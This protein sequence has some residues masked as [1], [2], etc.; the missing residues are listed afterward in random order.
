MSRNSRELINET[1]RARKAFTFPLSETLFE[2]K[3]LRIKL[4][5]TS[6]DAFPGIFQ[7]SP[8]MTDVRR[9]LAESLDSLG[10]LKYHVSESTSSFAEQTD[11]GLLERLVYLNRRSSYPW[12]NGRV[13]DGRFAGNPIVDDSQLVVPASESVAVLSSFLPAE[14]SPATKQTRNIAGPV[15]AA[16]LLTGPPLLSTEMAPYVTRPSKRA[17][18]ADATEC[19]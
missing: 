1:C 7:I 14:G 9:L 16:R 11:P 8:G 17:L 12:R 15:N 4:L 10:D 19:F 6:A 5:R 2:G 18:R 13:L 3:K